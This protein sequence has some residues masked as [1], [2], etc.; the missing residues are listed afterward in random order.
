MK[1]KTYLLTYLFTLIGGILLVLL[2]GR[3]ELWDG[4][5]IVVGVL[6]FIP[7]VLAII[8]ALLNGKRPDEYGRT[9]RQWLLLVPAIGGLILGLFMIVSPGLFINYLIIAFGLI[10]VACGGLQLYNLI[11]RM[12]VL[13]VSPYFLIAPT[14]TLILGL[15]ILILG[16]DKVK[17]IA[18][19]MT[20]I[21]LILYSI[22]G[23]I[24][25]YHKEYKLRRHTAD[26]TS[27]NIVEV[28]ND[29][30]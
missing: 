12:K 14:L 28:K 8:N 17:N 2:N 24:G 26:Y 11:P 9:R 13:K 7:S 4:I 22:N 15:V 3:T 21:M 10:L 20:G 16:S 5:V 25:Y 27:S 30:I 19:I 18:A 6:F 29:K 1:S 23:F